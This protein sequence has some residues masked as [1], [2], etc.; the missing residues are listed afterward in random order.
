MKI[1]I[2]GDSNAH[3]YFDKHEITV[4]NH[5]GLKIDDNFWFF[6]D[7]ALADDAYNVVIVS[8]GGNHP[9]EDLSAEFARIRSTPD[10]PTFVVGPHADVDTLQL[11]KTDNVHLSD[12]AVQLTGRLLERL[13]SETCVESLEEQLLRT[14]LN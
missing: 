1:L 2:F 9:G 7:V 11:Q 8:I 13:I 12:A 6:F 5:P 14:T 3:D 10:V 4:E